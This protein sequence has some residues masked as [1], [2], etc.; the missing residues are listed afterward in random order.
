MK[1]K[2]SKF[3]LKEEIS[4]SFSNRQFSNYPSLFIALL[5]MN[6]EFES[7]SINN[8]LF[9]ASFIT[10]SKAKQLNF[11]CK[12]ILIKEFLSNFRPPLN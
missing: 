4:N 12:N 3:K 11:A 5:A 2:I 8:D 7:Y 1:V 9:C 6:A 10:T